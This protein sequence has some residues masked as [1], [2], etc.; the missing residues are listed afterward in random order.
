MKFKSGQKK[1][2]GILYIVST[3]IGNLED[4]TLRAI[5][6]LKEVDLIAAEQV[7]HSKI[8]CRHYDIKTKLTSYNQH[9]R[10]A[11]GFELIR[12]LEF[13][14]NIALI[15]CA[16]TPG[17]SDPGG[18]LISQVLKK[19]IKV[20]PV[21]GVSAVITGL[22]VSGLKIDRF[23]FLGFLSSRPGKRRKELRS[24]ESESRTMVFFEAPHRITAMLEDLMETL[25]DREIV[26]L[27]ELTKV[28]EEIKQG[29][30]SSLLTQ[31]AAERIRGEYTLVVSGKENNKE[32]QLIDK[33]TQNKIKRMLGHEKMGVKDIASKL[34][35][36]CGMTYRKVYKEC[37]SIKRNT[38]NSMDIPSRKRR[39][40]FRTVA[41]VRH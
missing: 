40:D 19:D 10:K 31:I 5:R 7:R 38:N 13:G 27:R 8:L 39:E 34:S 29:T 35:R 28:Y 20:S 4:I 1:N 24:L 26:L 36:E 11:K 12:K 14:H 23:V 17:I 9:N 41:N 32:Q 6:I 33:D 25:G 21:P 16:G 3:P 22:S 15:T 2:T 30:I 18:R 37:L